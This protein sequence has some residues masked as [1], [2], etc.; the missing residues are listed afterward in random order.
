MKNI[1][2]GSLLFF[3]FVACNIQK[4]NAAASTKDQETNHTTEVAK[5]D[6]SSLQKTDT[7]ALKPAKISIK[8]NSGSLKKPTAAQ[9][10]KAPDKYIAPINK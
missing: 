5:T 2:I 8:S 10:N 4:K 9:N 7:T 6:T 3:L 1:Y